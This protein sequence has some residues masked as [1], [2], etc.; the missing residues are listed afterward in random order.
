MS[1]ACIKKET[2]QI[3]SGAENGIADGPKADV[4]K[5][6]GEMKMEVEAK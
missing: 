3:P 6:R 5:V 2:A 4:E 1:L